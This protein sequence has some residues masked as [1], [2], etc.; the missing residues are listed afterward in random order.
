MI[1]FMRLFVFFDLPTNTKKERSAATRFRNHLIN[2][3]FFMMQY[4]IYS[5]ICRGQDGIEKYIKKVK[6]A[7]PEYGNI[8]MMKVT[9]KQYA[10]MEIVLGKISATEELGEQQL[11]MF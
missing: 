4:S 2:H 7:L 1:R 3:G 6:N 10:G 11:L 5:R 8:R 9:E